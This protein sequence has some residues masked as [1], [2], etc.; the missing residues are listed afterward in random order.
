MGMCVCGGLHS[1]LERS[2]GSKA[3][4]NLPVVITEI[5]LFAS[6]VEITNIRRVAVCAGENRGREKSDIKTKVFNCE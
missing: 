6:R 5:V 4:G 3:P 2:G 1:E